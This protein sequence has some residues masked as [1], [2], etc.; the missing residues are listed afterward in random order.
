MGRLK[1]S[2]A[3]ILFN[4]YLL[5]PLAVRAADTVEIKTVQPKQVVALTD[6]SELRVRLIA[7]KKFKKNSKVI[8]NGTELPDNKVNLQD[9]ELLALIPANL[10]SQPGTV[11]ISVRNNDGTVTNSVSVSVIPPTNV[12]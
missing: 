2:L 12:N 6:G 4:F 8:V 11:S 3:I 1:F 5:A 9:G 10:V 7:K